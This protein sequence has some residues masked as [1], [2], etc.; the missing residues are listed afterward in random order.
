MMLKV[1]RLALPERKQTRNDF[2]GRENAPALHSI[3]S[4]DRVVIDDTSMPV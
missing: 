3:P 4:T 1:T 2:E